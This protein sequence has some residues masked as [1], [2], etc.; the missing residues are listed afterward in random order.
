MEYAE[1]ITDGSAA[2][3][4][5]QQHEMY[6]RSQKDPIRRQVRLFVIFGLDGGQVANCGAFYRE[7]ASS[8]INES[9]V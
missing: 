9:I 8:C 2:L 3:M 6:F 7:C 1:V 4:G 5:S